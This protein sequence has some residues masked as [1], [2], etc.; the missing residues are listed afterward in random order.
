MSGRAKRFRRLL[1]RYL[2]QKQAEQDRALI[3]S[4]L[5]SSSDKPSILVPYFPMFEEGKR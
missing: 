1:R 3:L 4:T 2:S 5:R